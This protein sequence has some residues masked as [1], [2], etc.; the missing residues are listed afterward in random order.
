MPKLSVEEI[1]ARYGITSREVRNALAD[2]HVDGERNHGVW[3]VSH[4]SL[5]AAI[6]R[7][8]LKDRK[9]AGSPL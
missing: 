9:K 3:T 7:G 8:I 6:E 5:V 2:G 4:A 1:E